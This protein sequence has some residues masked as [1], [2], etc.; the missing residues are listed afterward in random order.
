MTITMIKAD[1]FN[2]LPIEIIN[3]IF[4]NIKINDLRE[5]RFICSSWSK[6]IREIINSRLDMKEL[7]VINEKKINA[8][9]INEIPDGVNEDT[10]DYYSIFTNVYL[11]YTKNSYTLNKLME[12]EEIIK[13]ISKKIKADNKNKNARIR[14]IPHVEFIDYVEKSCSSKEMVWKILVNITDSDALLEEDF[15]QFFMNNYELYKFYT[16]YTADYIESTLEYEN[17][18]ELYESFD[19]LMAYGILMVYP[20]KKTFSLHYQHRGG[21]L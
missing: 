10:Y 4:E 3:I 18:K 8:I 20:D 14:K 15:L 9:N 16:G 6:I 7:Y 11:Y 21:H 13:F 2:R 1:I 12:D 17:H 19:Y 5:L